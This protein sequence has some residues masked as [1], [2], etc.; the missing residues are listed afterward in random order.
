MSNWPESE[1]NKEYTCRTVE[2]IWEKK[3]KQPENVVEK[4][5]K[6]WKKQS[7]FKPSCQNGIGEDRICIINKW[8]FVNWNDLR[9][10]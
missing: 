3:K 5:K 7:M 10:M 6:K 2:K 9:H 8:M 4:R 1:K